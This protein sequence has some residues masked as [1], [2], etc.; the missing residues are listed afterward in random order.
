MICLK[1]DGLRGREH[2]QGEAL[3]VSFLGRGGEGTADKDGTVSTH[4]FLCR[5]EG[6][7]W[8]SPLSRP[9]A[10]RCA[11]A[12]TRVPYEVP[13]KEKGPLLTRPRFGTVTVNRVLVRVSASWQC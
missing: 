6:E 1:P 13:A 8:P 3:S 10:Q 7:T 9:T 11:N 12:P 2:A 5:S 4:S